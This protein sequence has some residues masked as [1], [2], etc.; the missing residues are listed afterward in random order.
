MI[1][2]ARQVILSIFRI[3]CQDANVEYNL[4]IAASH[5]TL[6]PTGVFEGVL[7]HVPSD[8]TQSQGSTDV[9][10]FLAAPL[11][12]TGLYF[13]NSAKHEHLSSL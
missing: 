5:P 12:S 13:R 7:Y 11:G 6:G 2:V 3:N 10:D 4:R 8:F 9:A 1:S